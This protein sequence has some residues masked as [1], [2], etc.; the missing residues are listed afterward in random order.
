MFCLFSTT[1]VLPYILLI[2]DKK[3][4]DDIYLYCSRPPMFSHGLGIA[5]VKAQDADPP[6]LKV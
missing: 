4:Y 6:P 1:V 3:I 5:A 2:G